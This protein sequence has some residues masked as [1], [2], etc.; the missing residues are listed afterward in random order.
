MTVFHS[1]NANF[2]LGDVFE[3]IEELQKS[4]SIHQIRG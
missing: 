4:E 3:F 1:R 2:K